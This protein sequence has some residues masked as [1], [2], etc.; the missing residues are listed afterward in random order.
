MGRWDDFVQIPKTRRALSRALW[1]RRSIARRTPQRESG[2]GRVLEVLREDDGDSDGD[3]DYVNIGNVSGVI[4]YCDIVYMSKRDWSLSQGPEPDPPNGTDSSPNP[5]P[6]FIQTNT[7]KRPSPSSIE[8]TASA[9]AARGGQSEPENFPSLTASSI[10]EMTAPNANAQRKKQ[11]AAIYG[12]GHQPW[13]NLEYLKRGV[14]TRMM[15]KN[16]EY[17]DNPLFVVN[18]GAGGAGK[19]NGP[20]ALSLECNNTL[21]LNPD[22]WYE[23]FAIMF[24]YFPPLKDSK[25]W[26]DNKRNFGQYEDVIPSE[27]ITRKTTR[28]VASEF[29]NPKVHCLSAYPKMLPKVKDFIF[30]QALGVAE[31]RSF[32]ASSNP[33]GL[34]IVFDSTG[35]MKVIDE[36]IMMARRFGYK[37]VIVGVYSTLKNCIGRVDRGALEMWN[38]GSEEEAAEE[39]A[40]DQWRPASLKQI[41]RPDIP[42]AAGG[43]A[44]GAVSCRNKLQHRKLVAD[45]L[46]SAWNGVR[47]KELIFNWVERAQQEGWRIV[48]V[49]NNLSSANPSGGVGV[50]YDNGVGVINDKSE[51]TV[52]VQQVE[53]GHPETVSA[54]FRQ[55]GF[56][57]MKLNEHNK[58]YGKKEEAG[59]AAATGM[60]GSRKRRI[61]KRRRIRGTRIRKTV[62][63]YYRPHTRRRHH[64]RHSHRR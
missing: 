14:L 56:Y 50:I 1:R 51:E 57:G 42:P 29:C 32:G 6:K 11:W 33:I 24:G 13:D 28:P 9:S 41:A 26:E 46:V 23:Y 55:T 34:N 52:F 3:S 45:G 53:E 21:V 8:R 2:C 19:S 12:T 15:P 62:K 20:F 37:I 40:A 30:E 64:R 59:K 25:W 58:F 5:T 54:L 36:Y 31:L 17:V 63:K 61:S 38:F 7:A 48:L 35:S 22:E 39:E 47:D 16:P 10:A 18:I 4:F 43:G 49:E 27:N 60:G 44:A